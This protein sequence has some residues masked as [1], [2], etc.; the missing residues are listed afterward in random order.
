MQQYRIYRQHMLRS[1]PRAQHKVHGIDL[2]CK[3]GRWK[4]TGHEHAPPDPLRTSG[5]SFTG[6]RPR[7]YYGYRLTDL[8]ID[9]Q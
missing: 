8:D 1:A 7:L 2:S 5:R 3:L 9:R 4:V 6:A